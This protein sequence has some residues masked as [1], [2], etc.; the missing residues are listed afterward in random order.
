IGGDIIIAVDGFR[1][2]GIDDLS[3]YLE[4]YTEPGQ[5]IRVTV[6]REKQLLVLEVELGTRPRLLE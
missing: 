5:I 3:Y 4:E 6:I 2:T 1:I